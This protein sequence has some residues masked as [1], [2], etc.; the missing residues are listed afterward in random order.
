VKHA[1]RALGG[2]GERR[3][4]FVQLRDARTLLLQECFVARQM[5]LVGIDE[6][7]QQRE[8]QV[9]V[10]V[11]QVVL[12]DLAQQRGHILRIPD[13]RGH[14]HQA[15]QRIRNGRR[16]GLLGQVEFGQGARR[17]DQGDN[18]VDRR[19]GCRK[20]RHECDAD[21]QQDQPRRAPLCR[22]VQRRAEHQERGQKRGGAHI[23][24][25]GMREYGAHEP[26]AGRKARGDAAFQL[27][28]AFVGQVVTH[29]RRGG[30]SE[31]RPGRVFRRSSIGC[32]RGRRVCQVSAGALCQLDCGRRDISLAL[33][34]R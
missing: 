20:G 21:R 28:A 29:V 2:A 25:G 9:G 5:L 19:D 7:G 30:C 23:D 4:A 13:Q 31:A 18:P 3:I 34:A 32:P 6:V 33:P 11:A 10:G 24:A 14:D 27:G 15:A 12:F 16:A 26:A 8:I 1:E 17:N 22:G